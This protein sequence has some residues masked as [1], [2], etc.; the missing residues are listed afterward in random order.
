MLLDLPTEHSWNS[1]G[2]IESEKEFFPDKVS[3][4]VMVATRNN[5]DENNEDIE[6]ISDTGHKEDI[7]DFDEEYNDI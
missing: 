4:Q 7:S 1:E 3:N 5:H 2:N 6:C